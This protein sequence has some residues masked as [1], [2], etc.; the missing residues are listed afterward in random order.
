MP[1]WNVYK[2]FANGKRAKSPY[3]TFEAE[4]SQHFFENILPTLGSKLK[5]SKWMVL[6]TAAPQERPEGGTMSADDILAKKRN[7]HLSKIA[8]ELFPD[9]AKNNVSTCLMSNESTDWKWAW[10]IAQGA[11]HKFLGLLS[12]KFDTRKEAIAWIDTA[13]I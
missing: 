6:D 13:G 5:K 2:V 7:Q 10:C 11:T 1:N 9:I 4:E 3:T 8:I 12:E